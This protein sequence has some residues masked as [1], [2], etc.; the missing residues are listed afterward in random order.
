MKLLL[1]LF[2][3]GLAWAQSPIRIAATAFTDTF[4]GNVWAAVAPP[5]TLPGAIIPGRMCTGTPTP[6]L[7]VH[8]QYGSPFTVNI[9]AAN[10]PWTVTVFECEAYWT[11]AGKRVQSITANGVPV[12]TN[13][14]VAADVGINVVE[15][16]SAQINVTAG[17][18]A[19]TFTSTVDKA[20]FQAIELDPAGVTPPPGGIVPCSG[21][22]LT[23]GQVLLVTPAGCVITTPL[24]PGPQGSPGAP[25]VQGIQGPQ[26]IPGLP[27]GSGSQGPTGP[28]GPAGPPGGLPPFCT[29]V[30]WSAATPYVTYDPVLMCTRLSARNASH[31]VSLSW[32][33]S[34]TPMVNGYNV[35]RSQTSGGP[36]TLITA[37]LVI[38][39]SYN[40]A[41]VQASTAYYYV[42]TAVDSMGNESLNSNEAMVQVP[43]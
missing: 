14:D 39:T 28:T 9:P 16:K 31:S 17:V 19:I 36:Y 38:G 26:G 21:V 34:V 4:S 12:A 3:S 35:Y 24:L 43:A 32:F 25:G 37:A 7:F 33:A 22:T 27:G 41:S 29:G 1:L 40:D 18:A 5:G 15:S 2:V 42:A 13:W 30:V 6:A 10:G 8:S 11:V 20:Q 23:S